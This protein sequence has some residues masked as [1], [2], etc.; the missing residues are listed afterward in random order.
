MAEDGAEHDGKAERVAALAR[1]LGAG[2]V[3]VAAHHNVAWLPGG[4]GNRVDA[5]R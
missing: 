1:A 5:S 3:L 2:G 4:R